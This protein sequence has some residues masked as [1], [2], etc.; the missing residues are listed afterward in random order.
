MITGANLA[1]HAS[2]RV[3]IMIASTALALSLAACGGAF[4]CNLT[5]EGNHRAAGM[6]GTLLVESA[7]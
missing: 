5:D 3:M 4:A 6:E 7:P 2:R 1:N